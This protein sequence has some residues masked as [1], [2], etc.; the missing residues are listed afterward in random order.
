MHVLRV[1]CSMS[2]VPRIL[3]RNANGGENGMGRS[4]R[5]VC[6]VLL[7]LTGAAWAGPRDHVDPPFAYVAHGLKCAIGPR[8]ILSGQDTI[9]GEVLRGT[10]TQFRFD[11]ITGQ[12]PAM[13]GI[14]FGVFLSVA[15]DA[16]HE[17]L[18]ASVTHPPMGPEGRTVQHWPNQIIPDSQIYVGYGIEDDFERV[19]GPWV[20]RLWRGDEVVVQ[21]SFEMFPQ[22]ALAHTEEI[23]AG[24]PPR[25]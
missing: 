19:P 18:M 10:G 15:A 25:S 13:R 4:L 22:G 7:A 3:G 5:G 21:R 2:L 8:E 14:S 1:R 17:V 23:C 11:V 9:D 24:G 12:V 16:E 20:F 6:I